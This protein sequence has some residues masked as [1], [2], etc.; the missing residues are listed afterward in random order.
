VIQK[1]KKIGEVPALY[2]LQMMQHVLQG[3]DYA[4][5]PQ[6]KVAYSPSPVVAARREIWTSKLLDHQ[7]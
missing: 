3:L 4:A 2:K 7:R 6:R 5:A 1:I